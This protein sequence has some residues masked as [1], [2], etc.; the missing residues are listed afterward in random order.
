[1]KDALKSIGVGAL[2]TGV[3]GSV[4]GAFFWAVFHAPQAIFV[5]VVVPGL[6]LLCYAVGEAA[7]NA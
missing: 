4:V 5:L 2:I 3:C 7:R 6:V 1:M